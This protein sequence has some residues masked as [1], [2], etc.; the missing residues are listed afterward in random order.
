MDACAFDG[1]CGSDQI[2]AAGPRSGADEAKRTDMT[3]G[4]RALLL[5]GATGDL[6]KRM[7]LPSLFA[8]HAEGLIAPDLSIIGTA[9]SD[10]DDAAYRALAADALAEYLP[11]ERMVPDALPG[12]LD[13]LRYVPLDAT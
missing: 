3:G 11:A 9:R 6:A 1:C 5:F 8:L 13:R 2:G 12:F 10:L 4:A 7:L